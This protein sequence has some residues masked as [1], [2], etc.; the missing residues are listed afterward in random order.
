MSQR[1]HW[2]L[3]AVIPNFASSS[4][5]LP[6]PIMRRTAMEL[7]ELPPQLCDRFRGYKHMVVIWQYAPGVSIDGMLS[8]GAQDFMFAFGHSL[9]ILTD[10][11][12]MFVTRRRDQILTASC[13]IQVWWRMPWKLACS[14]QFESVNAIYNRH[15]TPVIHIVQLWGRKLKLEL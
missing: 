8:A 11:H 3:E 15:S 4:C 14:P 2:S 5:V 7:T 10:D 9:G 12:R 13:Q 1:F 6:I